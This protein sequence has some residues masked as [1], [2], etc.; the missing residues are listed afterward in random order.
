LTCSEVVLG[1]AIGRLRPITLPGVV[2]TAE[3]QTR[4]DRKYVVPL[5]VLAAVLDRMAD[6]LSVLEIAGRRLFRYES[7]YFDTPEL[8][9]YHQHAHGRRGRVKVRTRTYLDSGECLLEFKRVGARGETVKERY[10]YPMSCRDELD[11]MALQL[12]LDRVGGSI[13]TTALSKVL[14]TSYHRATLVDRTRGSRLTCDVNLSFEAGAGRAFGPLDG[15]VV[16]ESKT[17]GSESPVDRVLR[18]LGS[19][20]L[21]L[22]KYCVGMAVLD[23]RL[24]ANRWN[25]ELRAHFGWTPSRDQPVAWPAQEVTAERG[26]QFWSRL[27]SVRAGAW[28]ALPQ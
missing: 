1:E 4:H 7:V 11:A 5:D 10:P 8:T 3:L 18:G 23:P 16:L 20:P 22:S 13:V 24:P 9:A 27:A 25:R 19:R 26:P 21:S 17:V 15:V 2:A 12:A 28:R 6:D 14:T